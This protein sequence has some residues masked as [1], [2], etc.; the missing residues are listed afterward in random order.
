MH[1]TPD[2]PWPRVATFVRQHTHDV[3][4]GLNSL[5]LE[6]S[7]LADIVTDP[8]AMD[9]L[10]RMRIQIRQ[11][12]ADLRVLSAKFQDQKPSITPISA[13][14]MLEI[15]KEQ[16]ASLPAK[17]EVEWRSQVNGETI[18]ADIGQVA[19]VLRELLSNAQA[20]GVGAKITASVSSDGEN[21]IFELV[22]PKDTPLQPE[23]WDQAPLSSTRRHGYGLGLWEVRRVIEAN[24]G[25]I[26]RKYLP[27]K[28]QLVTT[29]TFPTG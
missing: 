20:F 12:A 15:W 22:E 5:E 23:S 10:S 29:L 9:S 24:G 11:L 3:R 14:E 19:A 28:K 27:E 6:A 1:S 26:R 25:T 17:P 4:N 18:S 2:I 16:L 7:L 21:V 13:T 8:E